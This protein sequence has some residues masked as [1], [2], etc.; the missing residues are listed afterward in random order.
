[1][2]ADSN[3]TSRLIENGGLVL[4]NLHQ[5]RGGISKE[6]GI[7]LT[8]VAVFG[9]ILLGLAGLV[10]ELGLLA[11]AQSRMQQVANLAALSAIEQYVRYEPAPGA[12]HPELSRREA[13]RERANQILHA[14][15]IW[16]IDATKLNVELDGD[17]GRIVFGMWYRFDPDG[18]GGISC[19]K[20]PCFVPAADTNSQGN[21]VRLSVRNDSSNPFARFLGRIFGPETLTVQSEATATIIKRCMAFLL[22]LSLSSIADSHSLPARGQ[23]P[24]WLD[25]ADPLRESPGF[26]GDP[27]PARHVHYIQGYNGGSPV[28]APGEPFPLPFPAN[29]GL[30]AYV[31]PPEKCDYGVLTP[32][33][34]GI[35][36]S[37]LMWCSLLKHREVADYTEPTFN[38]KAYHSRED[39]R[40]IQTPFGQNKV[41]FDLHT[42]PEPF[43]TFLLGFNAALRSVY[44]QASNADEAMIAGFSKSFTYSGVSR[45][46]PQPQVVQG[47]GVRSLT[48]NLPLLIHLTNIENIGNL[49]V[50]GAVEDAE[51]PS[52]IDAGIFPIFG[53]SADATATNIPGAV[54]AAVDA[55]DASCL[56]SDRKIIVLATDGISN[57]SQYGNN[58]I[59]CGSSYLSY[60]NSENQLLARSGYG[61]LKKL[62]ERQVA[63]TVLHAGLAVRPNFLKVRTT[64]P[65]GSDDCLLDYDS[66]LRRGFTSGI[67]SN[68]NMG[69]Y[70]EVPGAESSNQAVSCASRVALSPEDSP[71]DCVSPPGP[72]SWSAGCEY[73]AFR[74]LGEPGVVFGRPAS[75]MA[76]LAMRSGGRYCPILP[77]LGQKSVNN[78][79]YVDHD[80]DEPAN[81]AL[82]RNC[83]ARRLRYSA[84][85]ADSTIVPYSLELRT[86]GEQ[87]A[88]C[89]SLAAGGNPF[90]L[91]EE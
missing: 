11:V 65:N 49:G 22:D 73:Q 48:N 13:T 26:F 68:A 41:Y 50:D 59:S 35:N 80:N 14:N 63:L 62:L 64:C 30:F 33:A 28:Y 36:Y 45:R 44:S 53:L 71:E 34:G 39:Y 81:G 20:Y 4:L 46:F 10:I 47:Q 75:V 83:T 19:P 88:D 40:R 7:Y 82:C 9:L 18:N 43:S 25:E 91:V 3:T 66:A 56:P 31:D 37:A 1:M 79:A 5:S 24:T 27:D 32:P 87:A 86:P 21:A 8:L 51:P 29:I 84:L 38:P 78:T 16:G 61:I 76:E 72:Y 57:C 2:S 23:I 90:I 69:A 58:P 12:T 89:A 6:R 55:L 17:A 52:I 54:S 74:Q 77:I 67:A 70:C 60:I 42:R 85:P 15:S